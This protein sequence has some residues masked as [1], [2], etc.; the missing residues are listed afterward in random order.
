MKLKTIYFLCNLFMKILRN[1]ILNF[2]WFY[3]FI[4]WP[5]SLAFLFF[6]K[7]FIVTGKKYIPRDKPVLLAPNH[8]NAVLDAYA[9]I[10][11]LSFF[12]PV[13]LA[14]ADVFKKP[15]LAWILQIM[16]I[17]PIYRERD[18][19]DSL[20]KNNEIFDLATELLEKKKVIGIFPE[21]RHNN[22]R[23]LLPLKK[24][25]P[26]VALSALAKNNF[27]LDLQ[28]VPIGIYYS[29]YE[30]TNSILHVNYG[31]PIA[32]IDYAE[33]YKQNKPK[34]LLTLRN[35]LEKAIKPLMIDIQN[36]KYNDEY[37]LLRYVYNQQMRNHLA[38]KNAQTDKFIADKETIKL[39]DNLAN[40]NINLFNT[41]IDQTDAYKKII[42]Q[43]AIPD[44]VVG[45]NNTASLLVLKSLALISFLPIFLYSY[46]NSILPTIPSKL[47]IKKI[48][49][50][51][52]HSSVKFVLS[53]ILFPIFYTL[54][55]LTVYFVWGNPVFCLIYFIS[56]FAAINIFVSCRQWYKDL[57]ISWKFFSSRN[58]SLA[59][60]LK[61]RKSLINLLDDAYST[62]K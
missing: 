5:F 24:G 17:L 22:K 50:H 38:L 31:K 13:F 11:S 58:N 62:T 14:R 49:E 16:K 30:N 15:A 51:Q 32:V 46:V 56:L 43:A 28:I 55:T 8:Q 40:F 60:A 59:S 1:H 20:D 23:F 29:N 36:Q 3:G 25:V 27:L 34:A 12:Q 2:S 39:L 6:Y 33:L 10:T 45:N 53:L 19:V 26:R 18:G 21:G 37:E 42:T 4:R 9:I 47:L 57:F 35:D 7:K 54:Q 52:F 41:I 44:Y 61:L 48:K